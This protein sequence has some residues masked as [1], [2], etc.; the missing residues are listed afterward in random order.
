MRRMLA[1]SGSEGGWVT[2]RGTQ[3]PVPPPGPRRGIP[4]EVWREEGEEEEAGEGGESRRMRGGERNREGLGFDGGR[5]RRATQGLSR[6][7][8]DASGCRVGVVTRGR[9]VEL[10]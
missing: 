5:G 10:N 9:E 8:W 2:K 6:A 3:S 7:R 1:V 4:E